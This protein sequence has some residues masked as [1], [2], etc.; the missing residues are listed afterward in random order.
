MRDFV[1]AQRVDVNAGWYNYVFYH[2]Y[3]ARSRGWEKP[4]LANLLSELPGINVVSADA[5]DAAA[6]IEKQH[7][8]RHLVSVR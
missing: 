2:V 7:R 8:S 1:V 3:F 6:I 4:Q 5:P